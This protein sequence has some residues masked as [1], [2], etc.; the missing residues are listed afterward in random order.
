MYIFVKYFTKML[1]IFKIIYYN[2]NSC[3]SATNPKTDNVKTA[4]SKKSKL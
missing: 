1:A 3:L 4:L 2:T